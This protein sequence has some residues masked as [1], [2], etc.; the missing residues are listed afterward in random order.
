MAKIELILGDCLQEMKKIPDKSIDLVL[1][2]PPYGIGFDRE[3]LSM[4]CGM[5][6]DGSQ[7]VYNKW[8]NPRAKGYETKNWDIKPTQDVFNEIFRISKNQIIWGGNYFSLPATGGWLVWDKMVTM[9][10]LSKCELA[11]T[12][13]LGHIEIF[14]YL[15]AGFRKQKPEERYHPTQKPKEVMNWCIRFLPD[16][17]T[18]LDPFMGSGTT[19]VACKE[20]H[21]NFIGIEIEPKYFEIAKRRIDQAQELMFI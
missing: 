17:Q 3:N 9:T 14:H 8:T 11:W 7:R 6:K 1:T 13:F 4:S 20:L 10:S 21:R 16:I 5:R 19:G 2:D 12:S 15:W 18:I